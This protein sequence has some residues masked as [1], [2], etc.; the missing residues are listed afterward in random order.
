M[1]NGEARRVILWYIRGIGLSTAMIENYGYTTSKQAWKYLSVRH[2]VESLLRF[3]LSSYN[4]YLQANNKRYTDL[5]QLDKEFTCNGHI[6]K[7]TEL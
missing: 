1:K 7:V 4:Y 5:E 2:K 6:Y 3:R